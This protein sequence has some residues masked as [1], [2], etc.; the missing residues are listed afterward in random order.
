MRAICCPTTTR[1]GAVF[2]FAEAPLSDSAHLETGTRVEQVK[3]QG[4]PASEVPTDLTFTPVSGSV[5]LVYDATK[6]VGLGLMLTSAARAPAQ[7]ELFAQGPHDGPGTY[8][9]GNPALKEERANSLEG[10][11]RLRYSAV[12][13]DASLWTARFSNYIYGNLTGSTCDEDGTC[14]PNDSLEFKQLLYQQADATFRGAETT[15]TVPLL[16][17][18]GSGKLD[19]LVLA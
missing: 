7:T 17:D 9:I 18:A 8:E 11:L 19:F 13:V 4:T 3:I 16:S 12:R 2:G 1:T 14:V 6:Q 5:G 10:T 15:V